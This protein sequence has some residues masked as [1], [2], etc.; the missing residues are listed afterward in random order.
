MLAGKPVDKRTREL[1]PEHFDVVCQFLAY[2]PEQTAL[3]KELRDY[4]AA[5]LDR[6]FR[7]VLYSV[8]LVGAVFLVLALLFARS[9][10]RPIER[11]TAP[12]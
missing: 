9:I 10:V 4:F 6:L 8:A 1:L 12:A 5:P 3:Q 7:I 11:E 2:T